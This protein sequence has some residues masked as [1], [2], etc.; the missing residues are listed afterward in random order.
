MSSTIAP[1]ATVSDIEDNENISAKEAVTILRRRKFPERKSILPDRKS[2]HERGLIGIE[3]S[4]FEPQ[5][6]FFYRDR[7]GNY[8]PHLFHSKNVTG[9]IC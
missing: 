1:A 3:I 9:K 2:P 7:N 6:A 4:S 8:N 5:C